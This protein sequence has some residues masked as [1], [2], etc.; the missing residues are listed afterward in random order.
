LI[1]LAARWATT[2]DGVHAFLGDYPGE[3]DLPASGPIGIP[4]WLAWQ[5]FF[6][7]FFMALIVR[8]GLGMRSE[9]RPPAYW[10]P[11]WA[12]GRKISLTLWLHQSLD[13]LWIANG[14]A[15]VVLLFATGQWV[16]VVPTSW[17]VLPNA[18]SAGL[19]YLALDWPTENG[20][21]NYNALQQ[22]AYFTT[23]FIAAPL[24]V[25]TGV[26]MSNL[27]PQRAPRLD[28]VYPV[29]WARSLHFPVMLYFVVFTVVHV[30][31]VLATGA[32][33]NL[34]HMYAARGSTDPVAYSTDWTGIVI[35]AL[36]LIVVASVVVAAR[37]SLLAPI[38]N[39]IGRVS[40]R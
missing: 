11:R 15:Y 38:A 9:K 22:L 36:S 1:V 21:V 18:V 6:N 27:W 24:A 10:T 26:R 5:H 3:Y 31:L 16:R 35:F 40:S 33:R 17:E 37:P 34:N 28:R 14:I 20:W 30:A 19:Q 12:R 32:L 39:L 29:A 23:V 8:S 7:V 2:L 13:V 4:A 25:T